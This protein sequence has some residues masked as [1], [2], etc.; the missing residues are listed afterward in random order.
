M[1]SVF[2][3]FLFDFVFFTCFDARSEERRRPKE[4]KPK[5]GRKNR[6]VHRY[7]E[8]GYSS[9]KKIDK[10]KKFDRLKNKECSQNQKYCSRFF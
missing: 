4:P 3:T 2:S 6:D 9:I 8:K 7:K 10:G 1:L 5:K